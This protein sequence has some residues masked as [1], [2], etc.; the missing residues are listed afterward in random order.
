MEA[1]ARHSPKN[2]YE[3]SVSNVPS[4]LSPKDLESF[5]II[6]KNRIPK[7]SLCL[8]INL[9]KNEDYEEN[10]KIIEKYKNLGVIKKFEFR[11]ID[12]EE[13]YW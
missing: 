2:F 10:M 9:A 6:W 12:K 5:F 1:V 3:L 4:E 11:G 13:L 8:S 7:K